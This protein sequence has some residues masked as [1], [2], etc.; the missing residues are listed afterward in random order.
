MLY[1][2]YFTLGL[3]YPTPKKAPTKGV[4]T[5]FGDVVLLLHD[6]LQ[7]RL[8]LDVRVLAVLDHVVY[9]PAVELAMTMMFLLK[10]Q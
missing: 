2:R 1:K 5:L 8:P 3:S 10:S 4:V 6:Q 7:L 9:R